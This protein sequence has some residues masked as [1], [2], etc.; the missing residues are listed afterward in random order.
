MSVSCL[1]P[2]VLFV[3]LALPRCQEAVSLYDFDEDGS[4]DADDCQ[5]SNPN[6]Y[7]GAVDVYAEGIAQKLPHIHI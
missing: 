3:L 5:P 7:P 4:L 1:V 2:L 6:V